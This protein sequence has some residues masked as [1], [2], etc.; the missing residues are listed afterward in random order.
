MLDKT[1][2]LKDYDINGQMKAYVER[3]TAILQKFIDTYEGKVDLDFWN[4]IVNFERGRLGS[5]STS[6]YSGW[7]IHFFGYYEPEE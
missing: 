6:K 4:K 1:Y 7:L 3:M 5:G 2:L